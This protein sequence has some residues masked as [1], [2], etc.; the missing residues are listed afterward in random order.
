MKSS[1]VLCGILFSASAIGQITYIPSTFLLKH[2]GYQLNAS[3]D[4]FT[5]TKN[6]DADGKAT[7][8]PSGQSF[9]RLQSELSGYY[10][11]TDELQFGMGARFRRNVSEQ[12]DSSNEGVRA[13]STGLQ[14][15]FFNVMY[16]FKPVKKLQ[17]TMEG[18]FRYIPY[19]NT[20]GSTDSLDLILGDDGNELS[21]GLGV[22]YSGANNNFFTTRGGYRKA[23]KE[24]SDELYWQIEGALAWRYVAL[25]AGVDGVTSMKKDPY[26]GETTN[27]PILNTGNTQLYNST[28]REWITP[29]VGVN[30]G[31]GNL[32]RVELRAGQVVS[33]RSTDLGSVFG[34]QLVRRVDKG[35]SKSVD[36][37]FKS[38][39][40]EAYISKISPKKNYAIIDKGLSEGIQKGMKFDFF[41]YD[42]ST[43]KNVL[44][45]QGS[46]IQVKAESA[47][48]KIIQ[49]FNS[50]KEIR[51]GLVGRA[52]VK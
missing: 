32:W 19:T 1:V 29:Y 11:A 49:R 7:S 35:Q 37:S 22:T 34:F 21:G 52:S 51:D 4:L 50:K 9:S 8:L 41:D 18:T 40:V 43:G 17:Y 5:T 2:K 39:D 45:A 6:V 3:G 46:V 12:L 10:G 48:I 28:N 25:L 23:G 33:G 16:A 44:I 42:D 13:T 15:T 24:L 31:L 14:S 26:N 47:V 30:L 38:Y 20:E 36:S 27:R